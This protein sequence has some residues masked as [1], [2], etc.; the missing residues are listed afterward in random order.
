MYRDMAHMETVEI[1]DEFLDMTFIC[2]LMLGTAETR[3][4]NVLVHALHEEHT[5]YSFN[6][7]RYKVTEIFTSMG[8]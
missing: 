6:G 3:K 5:F 4:E 2:Q 7:T 1:P 8:R